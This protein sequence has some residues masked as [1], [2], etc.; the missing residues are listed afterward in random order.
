MYIKALNDAIDVFPYSVVALKKDNPLTS[1]PQKIT[2][3]TLAEW[4]V[5]YVV[6]G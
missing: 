1:F 3:E 4:D 6:K 2:N 5:Y